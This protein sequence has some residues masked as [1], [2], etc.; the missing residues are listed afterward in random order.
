V[1]IWQNPDYQ[2]LAMQILR[3]LMLAL[4]AWLV[5]RKI[6]KPY[7]AH[8]SSRQEA[9][10][11]AAQ[12]DAATRNAAAS[13]AA[14]AARRASEISRYEDNLNVAQDLASKDPRAVAMVLRSWMEQNGKH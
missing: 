8:L 2:A 1:A 3:Y 11:I 7:L 4:A 14:A 13:A 9:E 10:Q 5:W 12:E 6:V